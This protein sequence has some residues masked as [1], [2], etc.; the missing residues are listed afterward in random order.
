MEAKTLAI[1]QTFTIQGGDELPPPPKEVLMNGFFVLLSETNMVMDMTF[2][3]DPKAWMAIF[4]N[5]E[6]IEILCNSFVVAFGQW[7]LYPIVNV[8]LPSIHV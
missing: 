3:Q 1:V 6:T 7:Y 5:M 2:L 4:M 8:H